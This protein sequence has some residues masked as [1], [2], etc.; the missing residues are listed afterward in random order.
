MIEDVKKRVKELLGSGE[1]KGFLGLS[2]RDGHIGPHLFCD[3]D[4]LDSLVVGDSK[5]AGDARYPLNKRLIH[6]ARSYPDDTFGILIR[7]CD[8]R[9][10]RALIT[11]NQ[12]NPDRVVPVG[13]AC[14]QELANACECLQPFPDA[15]V[16]GER[17]EGCSSDSVARIDDLDVA[18]RPALDDRADLCI[19]PS[20]S[21]LA[22]GG[23]GRLGLGLGCWFCLWRGSWSRLRLGFGLGFGWGSC[24]GLGS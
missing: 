15:I 11:W 19:R 13:I 2:L 20:P 14:P 18:R 10:V 16:G 21:G 8:E 22:L 12:L 4:D 24:L 17:A 3:E 1:I 9:G 23:V 7:G 6:I 5:Q